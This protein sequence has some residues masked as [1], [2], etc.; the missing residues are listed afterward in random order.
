HCVAVFKSTGA[1][2][3]GDIDAN[4]VENWLAEERRE[5]DMG[6]STSN[7]YLTSAKGF[8]RWLTKTRPARWPSDPLACLFKL[9]AETDIRR[10]RRDLSVDEA[11]RLLQA[12]RASDKDFRGLTGYDRYLLYAV[13]FQSGLR[14]GELASLSPTSFVLDPEAPFIR[15]KAKR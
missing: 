6:I 1:R 3:I 10:Q 14:A 8:T 15:L 7:H 11:M 9:N 12:A 13:A 5:K 4:K 2:L